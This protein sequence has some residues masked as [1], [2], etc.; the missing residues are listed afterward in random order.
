MEV[1]QDRSR[2]R[3]GHPFLIRAGREKPYITSTNEHGFES[4]PELEEVRYK[5][6]DLPEDSQP[7]RESFHAKPAKKHRPSD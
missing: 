1:K 5:G 3:G 2:R 7:P 6:S 4:F